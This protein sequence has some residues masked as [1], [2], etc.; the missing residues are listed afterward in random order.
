MK[1]ERTRCSKGSTLA[2]YPSARH[3]ISK[4]YPNV[5]A[6]LSELKDGGLHAVV[7]DAP[8]L[9]Y[10]AYRHLGGEVCGLPATFERL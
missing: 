10:E 5:R 2:R 4:R 3:I 9:R 8:I 7:S 1:Y 6:A